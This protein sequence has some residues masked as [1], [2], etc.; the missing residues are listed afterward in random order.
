M[1]SLQATDV[2]TLATSLIAHAGHGTTES[3]NL[4]HYVAE[5]QH[6]WALSAV[7]LVTSAFVFSGLLL[8]ETSQG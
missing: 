6:L 3:S 1:L 7:V 4:W 8:R 2:L 5:P